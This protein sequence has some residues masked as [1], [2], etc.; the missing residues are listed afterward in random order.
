MIKF[1]PKREA[2][3]NTIKE[4]I[5]QDNSQCVTVGI[6]I[7]CLTRW[8][9]RGN[10]VGSILQNYTILSQLWEECLEGKLDPD[11]KGTIIGVKTLMLKFNIWFGLKLSE[12]ILKITDNLSMTLQKQTLSASQG[13]DIAQLTITTLKCMRTAESFKQ[14]FDLLTILR[15]QYN[16]ESP[17]LPR[18]RKAPKRIEIGDGDGYHTD[19]IEDY[20]GVQYFEAIDL[21]LTGI[22]DRFDQPGYATYSNLESLLL[23]AANQSDYSNELEQIVSFYGDDLDKEILETQL[24]IFSSKYADSTSEVSLKEILDYLRSLSQPQHT[25]LSQIVYLA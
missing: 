18:K 16:V 25:F 6:R 7:F 22:K 3:F 20:Y 24:H 19:N 14:F 21:V 10:S 23:K 5:T 8:T 13:N 12:R 9:V 15:P 17:V 2:A 4:Q 1:S 11:I